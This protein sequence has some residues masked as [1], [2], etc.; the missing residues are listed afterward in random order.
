MKEVSINLLIQL[1]WNK[2]FSLLKTMGIAAS[3]TLV[4]VLIMP[5]EY[6]SKVVVIPEE[7]S[8][9]LSGSNLSNLASIAGV[10]IGG[11]APS[12]SLSPELYPKIIGSTPFVLKCLKTEINY[13]NEKIFLREYI[14]EEIRKTPFGYV[15]SLAYFPVRLK[16][17]IFDKEIDNKSHSDTSLIRISYSELEIMDGF[18]ERIWVEM[19]EETGTIGLFVEM[20]DPLISAKIAKEGYKFLMEY[21]E[22]YTT[23]K[24]KRKLDFVSGQYEKAKKTYESD[25]RELANYMLSNQNIRDPRVQMRQQ[26]LESKVNLSSEVY[27]QFANEYQS[28]R[29][30]LENKT[31]VF[32][33]IEPVVVPV[34]KASPNRT[35]ILLLTVICSFMVHAGIIVVKSIN[36]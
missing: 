17:E 30:Q 27:F 29:I 22:V 20:Q 4:L 12:E 35:L 26:E 15:K 3:I 14:E 31:P 1:I 9:P 2:R 18:R 6:V 19:D 11:L 5:N 23:A 21:I 32:T 36:D 28:S 10:D 16:R 7:S 33:V 13:K 34:E 24:E 25:Q 8:S